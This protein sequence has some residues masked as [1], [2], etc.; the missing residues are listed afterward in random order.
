MKLSEIFN[1]D[2]DAEVKGLTQSSNEVKK[3]FIFFAVKG[4]KIDGNTF[5]EDAVKKGAAAIVSEQP[6]KAKYPVPYIKVADIDTAM[7]EAAVKFYK[8]PSDDM[9][10]IGITG[11]KGKTSISYLL[12]SIFNEAKIPNSVIGTINYRINGR[13]VM[14]AP[15]TTPAALSLYKML[16]DMREQGTKVLIMEVSS[17]ALELKR[18][19]GINFDIGIFT[20]LQRD[21]LDFHETFD[22]YF[23][24]KKKLF[25]SI[26][27]ND[28]N[29]KSAIINM[30]DKY[31]EKL[32]AEF[33]GSLVER[34]LTL[35][36]ASGIDET[37]QGVSFN[38]QGKSYKINLLGKHN[39]YNA[40][41]AIKAA[42]I[43]GVPQESIQN[44]LAALKGVPGRMERV[45]KGQLFYT[46]VDFA[47]TVESMKSAFKTLEPYKTS[48]MLIVFG[49]GG[50]R[51]RSKRPLMGKEACANWDRVFI[52]NDNPRRESQ[53]QIFKDI[54][55]GIEECGNF[56]LIPDRA[57]A[58]AAAVK[59]CRA[60]DILVVAGKGHEDYQILG[61][62]K[63]HFSDH[64]EIAKALGELGYV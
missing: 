32:A 28:K 14:Q 42:E 5:V 16:S 48:R 53:E 54:L 18:V 41:F 61:D 33:K 47:Y 11:T 20:N 55:S 7:A 13:V 35:L 12:E 49:C 40:L 4:H 44:G 8:S 62:K 10:V 31:G 34:P 19:H 60:G 58:I 9:F 3:G 36:A 24:A 27:E 37:V 38:Y 21:H 64:E 23:D 1:I 17:H 2:S 56:T 43:C 39:V 45:D 30:D 29:T 50:D 51:D 46:F 59:E 15:N 6:A 26:A 57:A 52:T 63:I 22:K 25:T